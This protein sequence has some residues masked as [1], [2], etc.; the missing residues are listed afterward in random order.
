MLAICAGHTGGWQA[1]GGLGV[2]ACRGS[3][4]MAPVGTSEDQWAHTQVGRASLKISSSPWSL[5]R[6]E[7]AEGKAPTKHAGLVFR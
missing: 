3:G 1:H 6:V 7:G 4:G 2:Q 5:G